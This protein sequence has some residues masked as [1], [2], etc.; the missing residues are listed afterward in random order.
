MRTILTITFRS[1]AQGNDRRVA[2]H[3][4]V[5]ICVPEVSSHPFRL[6]G[7]VKE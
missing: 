7:G 5:H 6:V 3:M 4:E 2:S 1:L